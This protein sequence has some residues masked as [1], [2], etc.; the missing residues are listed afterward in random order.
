MDYGYP[1]ISGLASIQ[2]QSNQTVFLRAP[3]YI[4]TKG[5]PNTLVTHISCS[6]SIYQNT[7]LPYL[8]PNTACSTLCTL[9]VLPAAAAVNPFKTFSFPG[10]SLTPSSLPS[11]KFLLQSCEEEKRRD[12]G[13][14][15]AMSHHD[16]CSLTLK[17]E[18]HATAAGLVG[19]H[20]ACKSAS[21]H[22][23]SSA[24][25]PLAAF[26]SQW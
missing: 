20:G 12:A 2:I 19:R 26:M 23:I 15:D 10:P 6:H 11:N 1:S 8:H 13:G 4:Q 24:L 9:C 3:D 7:T 22:S 14:K 21:E 5:K 18:G 16:A 25:L 17:A